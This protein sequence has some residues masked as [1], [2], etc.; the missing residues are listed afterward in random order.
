MNQRIAIIEDD[1]LAAQAM[2]GG[3][4]AI[5]GTSVRTIAHPD[6]VAELLADWPPTVVLLDL[7]LPGRSGESVL[8]ELQRDHPQALVIVATGLNDA[9]TAVRLLRAGAF[10]Y[11]TKPLEMTVVRAA[12]ER[13]LRHA[14]VVGEQ[15]AISNRFLRLDSTLHPAFATFIT[16]DAHLKDVLRYAEAI[17]T[18]PRAVLITGETG[19]GNDL[20]ARAIHEVS[21]R[22]G[23]YVVCNLGGLDD[24]LV[25]DALFGHRKGA[26][27][28][29]ISDRA[30][31]VE[32]A[33]GGTLFLDEIGD[34]PLPTQIKLLRLLQDGDFFPVG[35]DRPRQADIRVIA[36]TSQNLDERLADDR[37]RR[38]LYYR[39][40]AHQVHLPA[41][42]ERLGD[43][44]LLVR[45][46]TRRAALACQRPEPEISSEFLKA[47]A[48]RELP[49]NIRELDA[50]I[51]DAL[52]RH[53]DG[54]T[55][56]AQDV[57]SGTRR[58]QAV[59]V[60]SATVWPTPLPS[61][62][63]ALDSL[64]EEALRRSDGNQTHAAKL[65]GITKQTI[66]YRMRRRPATI[67]H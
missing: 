67:G 26:F 39:L 65:L 14:A 32:S 12:V 43:L 23:A 30:G 1:L 57:N 29:A 33:R 64:V 17:A 28:G 50:I 13:A 63:Q 7:T 24:A 2:A 5:P 41:L 59:H 46:L 20:V 60:D 45:H 42:R 62:D 25:S 40:A 52:A 22:Q 55:W 27:T 10:D 35:D 37:F 9:V 6:M 38:D 4:K 19:T 54:E 49:G 31:L 34:L 58:I 16:T 56:V 53:Q 61:M 51:A 11:L 66:S 3:I 36:A 44:T 47:L 48:H 18:S 15:Q 21:G 8:A